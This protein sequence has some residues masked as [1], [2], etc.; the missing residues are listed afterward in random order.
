[1]I[2][3]KASI[4]I[5]RHREQK[6]PI[7]FLNS[8]FCFKKPVKPLF[9]DQNKKNRIGKSGDE[10]SSQVPVVKLLEQRLIAL[11]RNEQ[12]KTTFCLIFESHFWHYHHHQNAIK[13]C[14]NGIGK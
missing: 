8:A 1:M 13:R 14:S 7:F 9:D 6:S 3:K 10:S 4:C 5:C 11:W 12:K 2:L